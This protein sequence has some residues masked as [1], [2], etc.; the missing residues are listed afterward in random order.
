MLPL[1]LS[2]MT[3]VVKRQRSGIN[4]T[5]GTFLWLDFHVLIL[6]DAKT[7]ILCTALTKYPPLI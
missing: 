4:L 2:A 7:F 5:L 3:P 1:I 6:P